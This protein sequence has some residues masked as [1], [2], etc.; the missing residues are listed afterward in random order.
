[1]LG[2]TIRDAV[3][4]ESRG[5]GSEGASERASGWANADGGELSTTRREG[6][7]DTYPVGTTSTQPV[8]G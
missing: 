5:V 7:P 6:M 3:V 4:V 1:M 8:S 2:R